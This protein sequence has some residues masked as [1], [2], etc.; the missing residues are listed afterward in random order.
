MFPL[1]NRLPSSDIRN[2]LRSNS[3]TSN[4]MLQIVYMK[5][6]LLASR[7]AVIVGSRV[8]KR[9]TAR[10]RIKR[11]VRESVR[12]LLPRLAKGW[13]CVLVARKNLNDQKQPEVE[14]VVVNLF[15]TASLLITNYSSL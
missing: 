10:N 1:R 8:E 2:V 14:K 5:N 15:K 11:L 7:F 3:R 4:A 9:A 13:D 12:H 6:G